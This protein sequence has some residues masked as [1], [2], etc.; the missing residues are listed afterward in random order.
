MAG[1]HPRVCVVEEVIA[2]AVFVVM[3]AIAVQNV[4]RQLRHVGII[5][6]VRFIHKVTECASHI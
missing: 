2:V 4:A 5:S 3:V 1:D 6:T